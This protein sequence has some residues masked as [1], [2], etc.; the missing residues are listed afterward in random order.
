MAAIYRSRGR[1]HLSEEQ[2]LRA[3]DAAELTMSKPDQSMCHAN[4]A[5]ARVIQGK[6][7][8][9]RQHLE[10]A[11]KYRGGHPMPLQELLAS[12]A[13]AGVE[14]GEGNLEE[15]VASSRAARRLTRDLPALTYYY[16]ETLTMEAAAL[17]ELAKADSS[18][19]DEAQTAAERLSREATG[20]FP[21][22][23]AVGRRL[24]AQLRLSAGDPEGACKILDDNLRDLESVDNP[25]E[26]G[27]AHQVY[28]QALKVSDPARS[29]KH[30]RRAREYLVSIG[31]K[32][33]VE[34]FEK[35]VE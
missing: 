2:A 9:A 14:Y 27:L 6:T 32:P 8:Q 29:E 18:R 22:L 15:A 7:K 4:L 21:G 13:Q 5:Q 19:R 26:Q 11:E 10:E 28:S 31:A 25:L 33:F 34:R 1:L 23:V 12:V 20:L 16:M 17:A 30:Q 24:Q 35:S 3:H